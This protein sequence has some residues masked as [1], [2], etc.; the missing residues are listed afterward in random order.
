MIIDY[1]AYTFKPGTIPTFYKMF[2][3][4]G[5]EPQK[6]ILGNFIGMFRT[7]VGNVPSEVL[8]DYGLDPESALQESVRE[9]L[10]KLQQKKNYSYTTVL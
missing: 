10:M 4:E 1:R 5:L 6:R 9:R 3:N 2:E 7:D 8:Q